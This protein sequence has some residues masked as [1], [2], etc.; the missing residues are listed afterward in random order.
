M[1]AD[2]GSWAPVRGLQQVPCAAST[3]W[4]QPAA[5]PAIASGREYP[6]ATP[7]TST[8]TSEPSECRIPCG[9]RGSVSRAASTSRDAPAPRRRARRPQMAADNLHQR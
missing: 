8:D 7:A 2:G 4:S 6:H 9:L 3:S 5:A 1:D